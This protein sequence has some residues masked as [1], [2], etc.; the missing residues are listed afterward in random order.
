MLSAAL[1]TSLLL[2]G[3]VADEPKF[4]QAKALYTELE[5]EKA[6]EQFQG[7]AAENRPAAEKG[8]LHMWS[9]LCLA[10][11]GDMDQAEKAFAAALDLDASLAL[12]VTASPKVSKMFASLKD[13]ARARSSGTTLAT[14][15]TTTTT[16]TGTGTGS[17]VAAST[18]ASRTSASATPEGS[19]TDETTSRGL[20]ALFIG[21]SSA[22]ALGAVAVLGG[23]VLSG[24]AFADL[25]SALDRSQFQDQAQASINSANTWMTGASVCYGVGGAL[26][27]VGAALAGVDVIAG[28]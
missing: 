16:G 13:K 24:L 7:L 17:A 19:G 18:S 26:F 3:A 12:P 9:G 27:V 11:I 4:K 10:G 23:A 21:G 28:D 20:S 5:Y 6:L 8:L 22:A 14:T 1:C 25:G 2:V 15:T